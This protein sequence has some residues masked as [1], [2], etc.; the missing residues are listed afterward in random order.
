MGS[1]AGARCLGVCPGGQWLRACGVDLWQASSRGR[2][3]VAAGLMPQRVCSLGDGR[4]LGRA[5]RRV[6]A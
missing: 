5:Q 2:A 4:F 1:E 3:D 6:E